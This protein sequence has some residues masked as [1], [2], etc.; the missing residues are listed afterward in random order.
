MSNSCKPKSWSYGSDIHRL[1]LAAEAGQKADILTYSS[2]HLGPRSL[3]R[4][5]GETKQFFWRMSQSLKETPTSLTLQKRQTK[6]L[7]DLKRK[8]TK[9]PPSEFTTV[10]SEVLGARQD[11]SAEHSS[12]A[13]R[14][15][16]IRLPEIL[17]PSLNSSSAQLRACSQ[18]K[19]NSSSDTESNHQFCPSHSDQEGLSIKDQQEI[20]QQLGR[21]ILAKPD[22]WA[23]TNVAETHETKLQKELSKLSA[24]SRPSRERLAVFSDVFDDVCEG[25]PV[26]GRILREI[27]TDYD[28]Y[29]NDLMTFHSSPHNMSLNTSLKDLGNDNISETEFSDAEKEV[30]R[31]EQEARRALEENKRARNEL[32]SLQAITSPE[33]GDMKNTS[34]SGLRQ[35]SETAVVRTDGVQFRRLQVLNTW[36]EIQQLEKEIKEKLVPTATTAA[37]ER[38]IKDQKLEILKL[39]ASNDRL[40]TINK[41]LENKINVVLNREKASKAIRRMLW[42]E[43][44]RDLQT[45]RE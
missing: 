43:I 35:D 28:L 25:S 8:E 22:L 7:P 40:R 27:K 19:S 44:Y 24:Q 10:E 34:L 29:V 32:R 20:K 3:D 36:E 21:Q 13:D 23:G 42:D 41:D 14:R 33:D 11:Q 16:D 26:F 38:R 1:L 15:E 18:K 9:E 4:P 37:T 39:I 17:Y 31:L 45:E 5:H 12:H 6:T 2:G 30:C